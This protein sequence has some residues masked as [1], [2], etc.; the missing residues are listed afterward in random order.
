MAI[1]EEETWI[2]R[3]NFED[4]NLPLDFSCLSVAKVNN[5]TIQ[6]RIL[7]R[8]TNFLMINHIRQ[9]LSQIRL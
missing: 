6:N 2:M 3:L 1:S 5:Q 8:Y 7:K 4:K 9:T